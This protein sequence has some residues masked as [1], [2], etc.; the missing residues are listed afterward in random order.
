MAERVVIVGAGAAGVFTADQLRRRLG[1]SCEITL[2]ESSPRVGGNAM[3]R[4]IGGARVE[5]GA[6][7][8]HRGAQPNLV[9]LIEELGLWD[10]CEVARTAAGFTIWDRPNSRRLL[11]LPATLAGFRRLGLGDWVRA[12]KFGLFIGYCYALERWQHD[13]TLT[14]A[15]W[16]ASMRL[17]DDDFKRDVITPFLYQF[18]ALPPGRIVEASAKY[19]VTYLMR[20]MFPGEGLVPSVPRIGSGRPTFEAYQ[21]L[22]GLQELHRHVLARADVLPRLGVAVHAVGR[23]AGGALEVQT[24]AGTMRA[25]HVVLA[26]DPHTAA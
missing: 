3:S 12:A 6:Q 10:A 25:D 11:H 18:V 14:V 15:Q 7:F 20:T 9:A 5:C 1:R 24:S 8:F 22:V 26:C 2:L 21:S 4:S 13:W 16:L 19:A 23:P 17:L